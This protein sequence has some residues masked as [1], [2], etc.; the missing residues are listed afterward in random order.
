MSISLL[1][2]GGISIVALNIPGQNSAGAKPEIR[3]FKSPERPA[4][5][6]SASNAKKL[7]LMADQPAGISW[8]YPKAPQGTMAFVTI[9]PI[10]NNLPVKGYTINPPSVGFPSTFRTNWTP[11]VVGEVTG[12]YAAQVEWKNQH[13]KMVST[14]L[15]TPFTITVKEPR[16]IVLMYPSTSLPTTVS[17]GSMIDVAWR[18]SLPTNATVAVSLEVDGEVERLKAVP[19]PGTN[20]GTYSFSVPQAFTNADHFYIQLIAEYPYGV[21]GTA[22][23]VATVIVRKEE[24]SSHGTA[25][26]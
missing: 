23:K 15:T 2:V 17:P 14:S 9:L 5:E 22:S 6:T 8:S 25:K 16:G 11:E 24:K 4:E 10:K 3:V 18:S 21:D 1:V 13:G 19:N 7:S 26:K 12:T 20:V